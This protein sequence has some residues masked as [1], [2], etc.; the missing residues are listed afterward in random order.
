MGT[1]RPPRLTVVTG[2]AHRG[3]DPAFE[4]NAGVAVSPPW[5]HA[6]RIE[7]LRGGLDAVA[8]VVVPPASHDED[9]VLA[10]HE[11][12]LVAF[13][14]DGYAR[15][16]DA[17]GPE[18]LIPD[19]FVT[20]RWAG[21]AGPPASPTAVAGYWC[22]DTATPV[23]AGSWAATREAVDVALTAADAVVAGAPVAYAMTRPP[24]HHSGVGTYGG[25]C[26]LNPAAITARALT[27]SGRVAVVDVDAHH[28]NG[29]Q[30]VFWRDAE[31]LYTSL[32]GD[33]GFLYPYVTGHAAEVGEGPGRGTT[34][35]HPLPE[36]CDDATYLAAL[37]RAL[38]GVARFDPTTVV[39]SLGFDTSAHDP[40]GRLGLSPAAY[41][42]IGRRLAALE[43][44]TVLVQEGGYAVEH[45]AAML[46]DLLGGFVERARSPAVSRRPG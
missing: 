46:G 41:P 36:G 33:P 4:L 40:I 30:Q 27:S 14:R 7:A 13:L 10:V 8:H 18:V 11:P 5:E 16:R 31:V 6:G 21:A 42:E 44:P 24:G 35:N 1:R 19:T 15:W 28:G 38:D 9:A 39:V 29:T 2:E 26:L 20:S 12:G 23:V 25:F 34:R 3:H 37:D 17:G 32:H 22:F 43:R 45:L